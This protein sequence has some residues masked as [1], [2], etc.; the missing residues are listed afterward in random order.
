MPARA[1]VPLPAHHLLE[2]S[3]TVEHE[4][5]LKAPFVL[6]QL[7]NQLHIYLQLKQ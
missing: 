4:M 6:V 5:P 3:I 2:L 7:K 1:R